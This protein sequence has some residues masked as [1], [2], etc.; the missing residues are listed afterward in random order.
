MLAQKNLSRVLPGLGLGLAVTLFAYWGGVPT[1]GSLFRLIPTL[2]TISSGN[3][4][5]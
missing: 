2:P 3:G 5:R 4:R 1:R